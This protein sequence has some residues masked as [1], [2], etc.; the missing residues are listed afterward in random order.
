M[1]KMILSSSRLLLRLQD[2]FDT[3][4][5]AAISVSCNNR[6][7]TIGD[8]KTLDVETKA[9]FSKFI[10]TPILKR[11]MTILKNITDQPLTIDFD[12]SH[13]WIEIGNIIV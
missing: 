6:Q 10:E 9:D 4:Y 11:L 5:G 12:A 3:D 8:T 7:L 1:S 2:A 13:G